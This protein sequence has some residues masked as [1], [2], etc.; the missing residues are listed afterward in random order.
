M[1]STFKFGSNIKLDIISQ[2]YDPEWDALVDLSDEDFLNHKDKLKM[3][4]QPLLNDYSVNSSMC[5]FD[6]VSY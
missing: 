1:P 5:D 2:K 4:I 3:V 6:E